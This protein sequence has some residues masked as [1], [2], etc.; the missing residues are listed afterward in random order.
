M[1]HIS[2]R[3]PMGENLEPN[4]RAFWRE[5]SMYLTRVIPYT[6]TPLVRLR[7][8]L[9]QSTNTSAHS[10]YSSTL[11]SIVVSLSTDSTVWIRISLCHEKEYSPFVD[12]YPIMFRNC[13]IL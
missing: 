1:V 6:F 12:C 9:L 4:L 5:I 3:E 2:N 7:Y 10:M 8:A 13:I 11:E